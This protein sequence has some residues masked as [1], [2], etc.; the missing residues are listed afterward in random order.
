[1]PAEPLLAKPY[2]AFLR[3]SCAI[4]L[5]LL[6]AACSNDSGSSGGSPE[7]IGCATDAVVTTVGP[8]CGKVVTA[9]EREIHAF[10]GIPFA[11]STGGENRWKDPVPKTPETGVIQATA[12]GPACPQKVDPP[13]SP[14]GEFSEDC[15]TLNIWRPADLADGEPRP[16]MV[17]L[18]GGSFMSGGSS[19]PV[20][21]GAR[22]AASE[23]AVVVSL[24]YRLGALGFLAGIH[25]LE[26]NYGL[27]DQQLAFRWIQDNILNFGGDPDQITIFGESAGAMSVG[28]HLLSV[29]SSSTLFRAGIMQSNPFGIPFKTVSEAATEAALLEALLGCSGQGLDCMR[30]A[31]MDDVITAQSNTII[32]MTSLLGLHLAGFLVWSP[33]IDGTFLVEDPT[34]SA[35]KGDLTTPV[36]M[37]TTHDE[38]VLFVS[39]ITNA[40]GGEISATSYTYILNLIFGSDD[41]DAIIALYGINPNGDNS[42]ILSQIVT[43]YLFGCA[44]RYVADRAADDRWVYEF[45]ENAINIWPA[46]TPCEGKACHGDDLPFTFHTD[47]KIGIQF[48]ENQNRLSNEMMA[49]W[50]AFSANMNPNTGER[51]F[52]PAF[53]SA[54]RTYMILDTPELM[55]AQNPIP[56]CDFWDEIGYDLSPPTAQAVWET[57]RAVEQGRK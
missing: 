23:D 16:V 11:E 42:E 2:H 37:G 1:M 20:Y 18:Y 46:V 28:L 5:I 29:P 8:V 13:Y 39:E 15:L 4:L 34:V 57:L 32:Q 24:N 9:D 36:I 49:Y 53:S 51:L 19:L 31:D 21:D 3:L 17:W 25:G 22:L 12:F 41:A 30:A 54:D 33:V 47:T 45:N 50:G 44:N 10:L 43:D 26:G 27:K 55:T 40:L 38:G 56:N 35:Q 52:W 14:A 7:P 6:T 48:D